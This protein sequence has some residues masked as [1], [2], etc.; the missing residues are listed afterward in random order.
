MTEFL[1]DLNELHDRLK[2]EFE[3]TSDVMESFKDEFVLTELDFVT[4]YS[5]V[6]I[7]LNSGLE[8]LTLE[9]KDDA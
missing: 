4:F 6:K 5:L 3:D 8:T 1:V 7:C 9:R 2:E